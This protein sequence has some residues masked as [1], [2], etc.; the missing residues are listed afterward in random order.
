MNKKEVGAT[1][2]KT[3]VE[4]LAARGMQILECNFRCRQGEVDIIGMHA[5]VLVFVEVKYRTG[6]G[7]GSA[8]D[9]VTPVKM[10][11]ICKV[12]MYYRYVKKVFQDMPIRYDVVAIQNGE[13]HWVKNAFL[14]QYD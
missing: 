14:H 9:A 10:R 13:I 3:A 5:G 11:K 12:A 8:L 7:M 1:W 4:Y 2:E 6:T